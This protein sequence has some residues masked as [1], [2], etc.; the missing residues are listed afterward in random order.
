M[1]IHLDTF[2][3][4]NNSR[5]FTEDILRRTSKRC[6]VIGCHGILQTRKVAR[7][8]W[9]SSACQKAAWRHPS[10]NHHEPTTSG[11]FFSVSCRNSCSWID[12]VSLLVVCSVPWSWLLWIHAD[13]STEYFDTKSNVT[14][15]PFAVPELHPGRGGR[16]LSLW[17]RKGWFWLCWNLLN[18]LNHSQA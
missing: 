8:R 6:I 15:Q 11:S 4:H 17:G 2:G 14:W 1:W 16:T 5:C 9:R 12:W 3:L 7:S 18:L 13:R 10:M